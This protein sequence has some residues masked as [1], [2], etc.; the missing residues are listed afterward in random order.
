MLKYISRASYTVQQILHSPRVPWP[1]ILSWLGTYR[2]DPISASPTW[3]S[4]DY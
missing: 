4:Y 2:I 1:G 3:S